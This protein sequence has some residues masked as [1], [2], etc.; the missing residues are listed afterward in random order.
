MRSLKRATAKWT[1]FSPAPTF[2]AAGPRTGKYRVGSMDVVAKN[3]EGEGYLSYAD[4]AVAMLDEIED[5]KFI[6]KRFTAASEKKP[7]ENYFGP[8]LSEPKFEGISRYRP[9]LNYELVGKR[10]MIL[11]DRNGDILV[12]FLTR[13][14]LE[15]TRGGKTYRES[16]QC[17]KGSELAYFCKLRADGRYPPHQYHVDYRFA[18]PP[19]LRR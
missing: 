12:N 13:G 15:Y 8:R 6:G 14:T 4:Y 7:D 16:Y 2:D 3:S 19:W 9:H 17:A 1:Y 5:G 10:F 18:N 11:M